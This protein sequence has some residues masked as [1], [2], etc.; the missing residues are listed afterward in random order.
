MPITVSIVEDDSDMREGLAQLINRTS[1][2]SCVS[3]HAT[4]EDAIARAPG[5]KPDVVLMDINLPGMSGVE[6]VRK[7]KIL[8][9]QTQFIM[10]TVYKDSEAIF[11]ALMAG[12][13]GYLL[14]QTPPKEL[15]AALREVCAG[16]A[17]VTSQIARKIIEAFR[18]TRTNVGEAEGLSAREQEVLE[19]LSQGFLYKEIADKLQISYRTVSTHLEHIYGKLHVHSRAQ[20]VA[21]HRRQA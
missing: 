7:L 12:A 20:A 13:N 4:A 15:L 8:L 11:N 1:D 2:F 3:Q 10:L 5:L 21:K 6:A 18:Q 16:G 14:K 17:P 9:P 19:L